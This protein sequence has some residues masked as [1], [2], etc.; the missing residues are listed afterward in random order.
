VVAKGVGGEGGGSREFGEPAVLR[1]AR[2]FGGRPCESAV[3]AA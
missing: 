3:V 1:V 2:Q